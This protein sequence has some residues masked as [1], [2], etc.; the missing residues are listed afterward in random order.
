MIDSYETEIEGDFKGQSPL[1]EGS[2]VKTARD[3]PRGKAF[4]RLGLPTGKQSSQ[5]FAL[6]YLDGIDRFIKEKLRVKFY[7]R[8]MDDMILLVS[9]KADARRILDSERLEEEK[10]NLHLNHKSCNNPIKNGIEYLG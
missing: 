7:V 9:E 8:Y 6:L 5:C 1:G 2:V 4:P 10:K 3:E